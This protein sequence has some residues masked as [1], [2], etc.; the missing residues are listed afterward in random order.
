MFPSARNIYIHGSISDRSH[1]T[2]TIDKS[3][4]W[5]LCKCSKLRGAL[6]S[7]NFG[8]RPAISLPISLY[9]LCDILLFVISHLLME[10]VLQYMPIFI[11][12]LLLHSIT[13]I[14]FYNRNTIFKQSASK[15]LIVFSIWRPH[16][17]S[18]FFFELYKHSK[19]ICCTFARI[20]S[21][22]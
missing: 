18:C 3:N 5:G 1:H 7:Q 12:F 15:A 22:M 4:I 2:Q 17:C 21:S 9:G 13:Y 19:F 14:G 16:L 6:E 10:N 8:H 20:G 11:L